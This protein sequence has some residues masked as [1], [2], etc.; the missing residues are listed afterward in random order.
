[1]LPDVLIRYQFGNHLGS[2]AL[3]LDDQAQ[4]ISYEEYAPY[5]STTYQAVRAGLDAQ[6]KRY[7][8][9]GKERDEENGFNYHGARYYAPWI[10]RWTA[11]DPLG[12]ASESSLYSYCSNNPVMLTDL[13]GTS[14]D[15][16]PTN[17]IDDMFT[18][19][20]NQAGFESGAERGIN[21]SS[22][23]ASP[24]GTAAD[25]KATEVL[26]A[27]KGLGVRGGEQIYSEVRTVG[28]IVTQIGGTP[29]GPKGS[30]NMDLVAV[31]P[32]T[33][34]SVGD[35]LNNTVGEAIGDLKYGGGV[36]NPKYN[37]LGI[38]LKTVNGATSASTAEEVAALTKATSTETTVAKVGEAL[39]TGAK[40]EGAVAEAGL[41]AKRP[42]SSPRL[43]LSSPRQLPFSRSRH[44]FRSSSAR[45]RGQSASASAWCKWRPP[46][47]TK[48]RSTAG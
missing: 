3:E 48:A 9:T 25:A 39:E 17:T 6:P 15:P 14:P 22:K 34:L 32:G 47:L 26:D 5:G 30:F 18:F 8:F 43:L 20:R 36:I 19:I 28:G 31:K 11:C 16:P 38:P 46:R 44:R 23:A 37:A 2:V 35:T 24:F 21:F 41:I 12:I 42:L 33:S 45:W 40:L 1:M 7:R 29:G 4:V 13:K 27:I 10:A